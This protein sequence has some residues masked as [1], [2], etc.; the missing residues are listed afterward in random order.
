[1][2]L[3]GGCIGNVPARNVFEHQDLVRCDADWWVSLNVADITTR[4]RIFVEVHRNVRPVM[5]TMELHMLTTF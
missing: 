3:I 2:I 4:S 5:G 1:M